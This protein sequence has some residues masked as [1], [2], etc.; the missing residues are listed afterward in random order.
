MVTKLRTQQARKNSKTYK[1]II[2]KQQVKRALV[3]PRHR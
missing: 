3:R 2:E 1:I